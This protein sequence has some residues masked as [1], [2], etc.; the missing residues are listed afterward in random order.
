MGTTYHNKPIVTDG[1]V[2]YVDPA[3]KLSYPGSGN[4]CF[5]LVNL[6]HTGSLLGDTTTIKN[7]TTFVF[8]HDNDDDKISFQIPSTLNLTTAVTLEAW[9]NQE[10]L[11][12]SSHADGVISVGNGSSNSGNYEFSTLSNKSIYFRLNTGNGVKFYNPT[13]ITIDLDEWY[14]IVCTF[15]TST[16]ME[17]YINSVRVG[18]G[19]TTAQSQ[20]ITTNNSI[21]YIGQRHVHSS[22]NNS[23]FGGFISACKIYNRALSASE[24]LQNY[25]ALKNRF[26]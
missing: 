22:G 4:N 14:H 1:L 19:S 6:S 17:V 15:D 10:Q 9:I 26:I 7:P 16:T 20:T 12:N 23:T 21:F 5:N 18:T 2:F 24:V 3:N 8:D 25:N 13:D 11:P